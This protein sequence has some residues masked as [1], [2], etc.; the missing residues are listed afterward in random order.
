[1]LKKLLIVVM[2]I[3]LLGFI[4]VGCKTEAAPAE[5]AAVEEEAPAEEAGVDLT[6]VK[7]GFVNAG[8]DD[9]YAQFGNTFK[10]I[11]EDYGMEVTEVNSDYKPEKELANVQDLIA[12]GVE[13]IAVITAGA[14]GSAVTIEAA[15]D[16]ACQYSLSPVNLTSQR[17]LILRDTLQITL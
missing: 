10:A 2:C 9:Y 7:I 1:M 4:G 8:P 13:A 15:N 6:G 17:V 16:Q 5:E 11:A 12:K 14:A 3:A